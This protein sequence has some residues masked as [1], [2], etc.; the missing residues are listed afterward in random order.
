MS[1]AWKLKTKLII[2]LHESIL[3]NSCV[4]FDFD[5]KK[6]QV[7][8]KVLIGRWSKWVRK[9]A[10]EQMRIL[11]NIY[12][13]DNW[14]CFDTNESIKLMRN[15]I[16]SFRSNAW[17]VFLRVFVYSKGVGCNATKCNRRGCEKEM[18]RYKKKK[19]QVV[20]E[21][22]ARAVFATPPRIVSSLALKL[23]SCIYVICSF[24]ASSN[25]KPNDLITLMRRK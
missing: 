8:V 19:G 24:L 4:Q 22:R 7:S 6:G 16:I 25:R 23:L 15:Q 13:V 11:P 14:R 17:H 2:D 10:G 20:E 9:L 5:C 18:K 3:L 21:M 12:N 1:C